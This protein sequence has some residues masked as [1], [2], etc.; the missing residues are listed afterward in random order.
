MF[1]YVNL[2]VCIEVFFLGR[3][4]VIM[5]ATKAIIYLENYRK[6]ISVIKSLVTEKTKICV[7][8]KADGYGHGAVRIAKESEKIGVNFLAVATVAEGLELRKNGISLPILLLSLAVKE[9]FSDIILNDLTP[10]VFDKEVIDSINEQAKKL[11]KKIDVHLKINTGM[12]RIGCRMED[13]VEIAKLIAQSSNLI[14]QGVCT[15]LPV[16]DSIKKK[17]IRFTKKQIE[18]FKNTVDRIRDNGINPGI[19]H[20]AA[21]GG[22]LMYPE[23]TF[24]MV[25]PGIISYGYYPDES[26]KNRVQSIHQEKVEFFP[27]ME[28]QT[29]IVSIQKILKTESVSYGRIW[30]A[31][32]DSFVGVIPIGYAD[33]LLRK[34]SPNLKVLINDKLYQ[35]VGRVCMDQCMVLL[36]DESSVKRWDKVIL[37]GPNCKITADT[38]A[39]MMNTISYEI[40]CCIN[41]RV[42]REYIE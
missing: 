26:I 19:V 30:K 27:V 11:N 32:K 38:W 3:Y 28:L 13:S 34:L 17:D 9:E 40:T 42:P 7:P 15:H 37:F 5:R 20:C 12:G 4:H 6:N 1:F 2:F 24:D 36:N 8:V 33:G 10:L 18:S 16:S 41:K 35:V 21:S 22:I 25:R 39:K 14:L 31:K 23:A 29:N